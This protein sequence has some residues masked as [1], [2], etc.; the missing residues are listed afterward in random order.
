MPRTDTVGR[1]RY[2]IMNSRWNDILT[3]DLPAVLN[4]IPVPDGVGIEGSFTAT[5]TYAVSGLKRSDDKGV[6]LYDGDY[7]DARIEW[8]YV[9]VSRLLISEIGSMVG[10]AVSNL[11]VGQQ[12]KEEAVLDAREAYCLVLKSALE[13]FIS[14]RGLAVETAG[15][16]DNFFGQ[17]EWWSIRV[18]L[19]EGCT[20]AGATVL[21]ETYRDSLDKLVQ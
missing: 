15:V 8:P 13:G 5:I 11:D 20:E 2:D 18:L 17:I 14:E 19:P 6:L 9:A 3:V 7:Y 16:R 10:R 21:H 4:A 12:A 1:E